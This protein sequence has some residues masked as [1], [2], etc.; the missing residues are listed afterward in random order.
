MAPSML[1]VIIIGVSVSLILFGGSWLVLSWRENSANDRKGDQQAK[2]GEKGDPGKEKDIAKGQEKPREDPA[3]LEERRALSKAK[4]QAILDL[5]TEIGDTLTTLEQE[6]TTWETRIP[7]LMKGDDGKKIA[8]N[9]TRAEQFAGVLEKDRFSKTRVKRM[10]AQLD[11]LI[12]PIEH[13]ILDANSTYSPSPT[14]VAEIQTLGGEARSK[15]RDFREI[16]AVMDTLQADSA[17]TPSG[18]K[19]LEKVISDLEAER[20][21]RRAELIRK[22]KAEEH[23]IESKHLAAAEGKAEQDLANAR[24]ALLKAR[25]DAEKQGI[26]VQTEDL[27]RK[28]QEAAEAEN[29]RLEKAKR[30]AKFDA[31]YPSMKSYLL[32]ITSPGLTQFKGESLQPTET[33]GPMSLSCLQGNLK[34]DS[35]KTPQFARQVANYRNDRPI[36]SFPKYLTAASNSGNLENWYRVQ[37]FIA[38]FGDI[39]VERKLLA[40]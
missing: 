1:R 6:V 14:I 37:D 16:K 39:M 11:T 32:P 7:A 28:I 21:R 29:K 25:T 12:A 27:K 40:P 2:G 8:A 33:K 26:N 23:D 35:K 30:E 36:G 15:L 4:M 38:E 31:E 17:L 10:R 18:E 20:A 5:K 19:T 9:P 13:A 24:L 3:V 34:K 22:T